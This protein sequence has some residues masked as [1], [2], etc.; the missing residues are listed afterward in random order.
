MIHLNWVIRKQFDTLE[1]GNQEFQRQLVD[2]KAGIMQEVV[3]YG[4]IYQLFV[5]TQKKIA[6]IRSA[7]LKAEQEKEYKSF[8]LKE[9]EE[10]NWQSGEEQKLE[11]ELTM[12]SHAEQIKS[13][14]A[15]VSYGMNEGDQPLLSAVKVLITQLQ[16]V[17][18][19]HNQLP[20]LLSRFDAAYVELKDLAG[21]LDS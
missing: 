9:L 19:Y 14:I 8:L 4:K 17:S 11:E 3:D 5:Q 16:A 6:S 7:M 18:K 2:A 21:E 15:K 12:L 13:S 10:L 1:L 20:E